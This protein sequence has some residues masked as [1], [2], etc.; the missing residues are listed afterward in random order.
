ML[1]SFTWWVLLLINLLKIMTAQ[2]LLKIN[3]G[4]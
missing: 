1:N 2:V 3:I 4:T